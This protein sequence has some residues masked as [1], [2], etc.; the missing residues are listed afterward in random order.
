MSTEKP[1]KAEFKNNWLRRLV[2]RVEMIGMIAVSRK[3]I[4]I[5]YRDVREG[6]K[7]KGTKAICKVAGLDY[8]SAIGITDQFITNEKVVLNQHEKM[9]LKNVIE[10]YGSMIRVVE[11]KSIRGKAA[12]DRVGLVVFLDPK[13]YKTFVI[14]NK[15]YNVDKL[16]AFTN[17]I[18]LRYA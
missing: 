2:C 4:V 13:R 15:P 1:K 12:F 16:M 3:L 17:T 9:T 10:I 18:T 7:L 5:S 8:M 11:D 6:K 14:L